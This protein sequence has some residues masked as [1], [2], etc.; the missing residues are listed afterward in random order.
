MN[1]ALKMYSE[2][3]FVVVFLCMQRFGLCLWR[4]GGSSADVK[5]RLV[6]AG[7]N[8]SAMG[9]AMMLTSSKRSVYNLL[10]TT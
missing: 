1:S 6:L 7:Q 4:S 8:S 10:P 2:D 5:Q 3:V 9:I